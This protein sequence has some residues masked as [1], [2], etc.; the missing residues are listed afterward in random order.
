M[1]LLVKNMTTQLKLADQA[2]CGLVRI[3]VGIG[4]AV[5]IRVAVRV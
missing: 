2:A 5:R 4:I 3:A 1:G